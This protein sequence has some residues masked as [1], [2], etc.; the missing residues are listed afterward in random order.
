MTG[1]DLAQ[2]ENVKLKVATIFAL[3][4]EGKFEY[5]IGAELKYKTRTL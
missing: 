4:E 3:S 2:I 1:N 5:C